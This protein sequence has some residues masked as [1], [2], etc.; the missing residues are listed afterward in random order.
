M[1][2]RK[3]APGRPELLVPGVPETVLSEAL[4]AR[5][6]ENLAPAPWTT[7]CVAMVWLC[8]GGRDATEA[9]PPALRG[10]SRG[11]A[12][13]GGMVRYLDTPVGT[14]D[15]VFGIVVGA[16]GRH[17]WGNIAFIAV[18][19]ETS[20]VGGRANWAMPKTLASFE[21]G[22]TGMT[23]TGLDTN[24]RISATPRRLGPAIKY[25]SRASVRQEFP[26][27]RIRPSE[28]LGKFK[29]RP[30]LIDVEVESDSTL[31]RWLKPGR[32][33]GSVSPEMTF[34]AGA[35]AE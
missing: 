22:L 3:S 16:Q 7:R 29:M 28:L 6:P 24:W 4:L 10:E 5:L 8:R 14:Y 25:T 33:L 17:P 32:H 26:D 15:E 2:T 30:T 11:H 20:V 13:I 18:D 35:P 23:A 1:T 21:G 9:L 12:V 27:G 34:T 31:P 19:S